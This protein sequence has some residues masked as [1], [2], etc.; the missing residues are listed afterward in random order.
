MSQNRMLKRL[1]LGVTNHDAQES[2]ISHDRMHKRVGGRKA[3]CTRSEL[4]QNWIHKKVCC[5]KAVYTRELAFTKL[6]SQKSGL[7]QNRMHNKA[8]CNKTGCTRDW[9]ITKC[10]RMHNRVGCHKTGC[11]IRVSIYSTIK[12][13]INTQIHLRFY[14][15]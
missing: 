14:K 5:L 7:P 13:V 10:C 9:V 8:N 12:I 3:G 6:D 2:R 11:T 1:G 4:S 15:A